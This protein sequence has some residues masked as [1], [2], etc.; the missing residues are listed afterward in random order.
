MRN[1][2]SMLPAYTDRAFICGQTGCGKTTLAEKL[3]GMQ[4]ERAI[5]IFDSKN[6]IRWRGYKRYRKLKELVKGHD[7][8]AI[9]APGPAELFSSEFHERFFKYVFLRRHILLY[10]DELYAVT[11]KNELAQFFLLCFTQGRALGISVIVSTQRPK[12]IPQAAIS[13]AEHNFLFRLKL[14]QDRQKAREISGV[15]GDLLMPKK[16][17]KRH[18]YYASDDVL[19]GPLTLTI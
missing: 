9:Y 19:L 12:D 18:F 2:L 3:L 15:G 4:P 14:P 17:P 5:V 16:L 1:L 10:V 11:H 8:K 7:L 6:E 13:E